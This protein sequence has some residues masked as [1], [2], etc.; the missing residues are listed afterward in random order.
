MSNDATSWPLA[1]PEHRPRTPIL[2]RQRSRF[3]TGFGAAVRAVREELHRL[4]ATA[5]V[6]STNVP[7]RRE[8]RDSGGTG[9]L[10]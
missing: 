3:A 4:G 10:T 1:W 7:L 2:K 5:P 6:V 9:G 8:G